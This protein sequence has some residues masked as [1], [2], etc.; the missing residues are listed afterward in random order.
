MY[1]KIYGSKHVNKGQ[2]NY[3]EIIIIIFNKKMELTN[4][5]VN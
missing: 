2:N 4:Q 3:K 5:F 1:N